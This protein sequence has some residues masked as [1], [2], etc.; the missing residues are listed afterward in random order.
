MKGR[1]EGYSYMP[2]GKRLGLPVPSLS[3]VVTL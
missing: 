2:E 3:S 1:I